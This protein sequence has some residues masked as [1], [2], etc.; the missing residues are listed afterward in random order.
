[1]TGAWDI[2]SGDAERDRR[3]V[4]IVLESV[5]E[6]WGPRPLDELFRSAVDR[7]IAV[8]SAERGFLFVAE[9]GELETAAARHRGGG[10][11][12]L[13]ERT[14]RTVVD[15][16]ASTGQPSMTID[17]AGGVTAMSESILALKLMSVMAVPLQAKGSVVGVL[18][19][20]STAR[21]REFSATDFRVFQALGG[22]V[23]LAVE[24][25]RLLAEKAEQE[26]LKRELAV[27]QHIQQQLL[28]RDLPTLA[29]FELGALGQPCEETSGDYYDVV[30]VHD[31][32][33]ALVVGDV[34]GHGLGPALLMASARALL[35]AALQRNPDPGDVLHLMNDYLERDTPEGTFMSLFLGL[36]DPADATVRYG[37]AGHNPPLLLRADGTLQELARTGPVL[38]IVE[39][40]PF[41]VS[42]PVQ[43][44]PGDVLFSFTDGMTEA[45][46]ADGELYGEERLEASLRRHVAAGA[47]AQAIVDGLWSDL[48]EFVDEAALQDDVTLLLVRRSG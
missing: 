31:R 14:S 22:V 9:G 16:V 18:Y 19:V 38:G 24:N 35:R 30:P 34:S 17:A 28:P 7:A 3:N 41:G 5:A 48:M 8:T 26:R 47:S 4:E 43:L 6:L 10:D 21:V 44:A 20:D 46:R 42:D 36:L 23:G 11:L 40:A 2:L 29:G 27:A 1:M 37:S 12:P 25:A 33:M 39:G 32:R 13:D 15:R 45:A